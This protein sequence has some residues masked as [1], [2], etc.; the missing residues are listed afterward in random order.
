[1]ENIEDRGEFERLGRVFVINENDQGFD[2]PDGVRVLKFVLIRDESGA[3][4]RLGTENYRHWDI[5]KGDSEL[6]GKTREEIR[7]MD[8]ADVGFLIIRKGSFF[9]FGGSGELRAGGIEAGQVD[10]KEREKERHRREVKP[11]L[12]KVSGKEVEVL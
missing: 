3:R 4:M 1:M 12:E 9:V 8:F 10:E 2:F 6:L 11:F 7:D 5:V